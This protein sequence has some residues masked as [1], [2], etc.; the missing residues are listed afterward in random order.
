MTIFADAV[1][2][3]EPFIESD[4]CMWFARITLAAGVVVTALVWFVGRRIK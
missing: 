4:F 1:R 2:N 3:A